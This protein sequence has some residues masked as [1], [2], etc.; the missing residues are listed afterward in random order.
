MATIEV[1]IN[2][3]SRVV[4]STTVFELL[5]ELKLQDKRVAIE[6]NREIVSRDCYKETPL[7]PGDSIEVVHFVGG[8]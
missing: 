8:G 5:E 4:L 1:Q 7:T 3:E 2:G 6:Q